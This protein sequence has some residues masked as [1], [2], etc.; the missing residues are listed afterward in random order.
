MSWPVN[1]KLGR[2]ARGSARIRLSLVDKRWLNPSAGQKAALHVGVIVG[3]VLRTLAVVTITSTRRS[4]CPMG[5]VARVHEMPE[6]A[7]VL[8]ALTPLLAYPAMVGGWRT[9]RTTSR[10]LRETTAAGGEA[11]IPA[12]IAHQCCHG[13]LCEARTPTSIDVRCWACAPAAP[14]LAGSPT[15]R[16]RTLRRSPSRR[17]RDCAPCARSRRRPAGPARVRSPGPFP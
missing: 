16:T 9:R 15:G 11:D 3:A 1:G 12:S 17:M 8:A 13:L 5:Q 2:T 6:K 7:G 10:P 14:R 4:D